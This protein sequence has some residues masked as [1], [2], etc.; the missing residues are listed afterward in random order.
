MKN[1]FDIKGKVVVLTGGCGVLGRTIALYLAEQGAHMVILD[2]NE[3]AGKDF[4]A[5]LSAITPAMFLKTNALDA[6]ILEQ[7]KRDI[8]ARFGTIDVLLNAAGGNMAAANI[9][10]DKTFLDASDD[11]IRKVVELNLLALSCPPK[12]S[13]LS[14]ARR[15]KG[16]L[17]ISVPSRHCV[18]SPASSDT[19]V[20]SRLSQVTP[21]IWLPRWHRS[22]VRVS[23]SMLSCR[24]S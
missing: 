19:A 13:A 5:Q 14:S 22:S 4:E 7:N 18:L 8:L 20:L 12:Y 3:E 6:D 10:P 1:L 11:A 21:S 24:A 9:A 17:S 2:M 15:K 16:L 23:V